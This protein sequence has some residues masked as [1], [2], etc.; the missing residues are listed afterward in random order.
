[1]ASLV[2]KKLAECRNHGV[3]CG[4]SAKALI[5]RIQSWQRQQNSH[6]LDR[7]LVKLQLFERF[8]PMPMTW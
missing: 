3:C 7:S 5:T 4:I 8:G 1:M 2:A 6:M